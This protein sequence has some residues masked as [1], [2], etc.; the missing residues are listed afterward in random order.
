MN[1]NEI[2]LHPPGGVTVNQWKGGELHFRCGPASYGALAEL[3]QQLATQCLVYA[4]VAESHR[5]QQEQAAAP[6]PNAQARIEEMER[7]IARLRGAGIPV[8]VNT[9]PTMSPAQQLAAVVATREPQTVALPGPTVMEVAAAMASRGVQHPVAAAAAIAV[10]NPPIPP[11][12]VPHQ[13]PPPMR[14]PTLSMAHQNFGPSVP[15]IPALAEP[16]GAAPSPPMAA[17]IRHVPIL[18]LAAEQ[19]AKAGTA[20]PD[21]PQTIISG[22]AEAD[23]GELGPPPASI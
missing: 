7:E 19:A 13:T 14:F 11:A 12:N 1:P 16:N 21:A 3:F 20:T 5:K 18:K 23:D 10:P 9:N 17:P 15:G 4:Q 6:S 8:S 22:G 2:I